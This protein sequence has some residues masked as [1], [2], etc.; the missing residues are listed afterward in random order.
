MPPVG[1]R[2]GIGGAVA[3]IAKWRQEADNQMPP[4]LKEA[5]DMVL[6][7]VPTEEKADGDEAEESDVNGLAGLDDLCE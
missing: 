3:S 4:E 7:I 2:A 6:Q 5:I 1:G